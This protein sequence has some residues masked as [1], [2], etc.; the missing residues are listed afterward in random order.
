MGLGL[1]IAKR[2][3]NLLHGRIEVKSEVGKGSTFRIALPAKYAA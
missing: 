1:S 3:V 2:L